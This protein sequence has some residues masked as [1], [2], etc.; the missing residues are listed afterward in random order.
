MIQKNTNNQSGF[1]LLLAIVVS[2]IVLAVGLTMLSITVKQLT[3]S[4]VSRESSI[5]FEAAAASLECI[6]YWRL[7]NPTDY[8]KDSYTT[9][10]TTAPTIT[11]FGSDETNPPAVVNSAVAKKIHS[12]SNGYINEFRYQMDWNTGVEQ[13]C[14]EMDLYLMVSSADSDY[15]YNFKNAGI[16]SV[17]GTNGVKTCLSGDICTM[18]ITRGYNRSCSDVSNSSLLTVEREITTQF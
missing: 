18:A 1:A 10:G 12:N 3:L 17:A 2:S 9:S 13:L 4:A 8:S 11:C 16:S 5:S 14:L 7:K 6:R 15:T